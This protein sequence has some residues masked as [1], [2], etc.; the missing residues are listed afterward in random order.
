MGCAGF[1]K[2][3]AAPRD[4][5]RD[6]ATAPRVETRAAGS[7]LRGLTREAETP[8]S[9]R[10]RHGIFGDESPS[11]RTDKSIKNDQRHIVDKRKFCSD[12]RKTIESSGDFLARI[13]AEDAL[14]PTTACT[15]RHNLLLSSGLSLKLPARDY[16][17]GDLL[18]TTSRWLIYGETG[19]GKTLFAL[20]LAGAV[21]SGKPFLAWEG[22]R[23]ARVMYLDGEMPAE[24]FKERM[25]LVAEGATVLGHSRSS[26]EPLPHPLSRI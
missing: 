15:P 21:A 22:I 6:M 18:C 1:H 26:R 25:Q 24:T 8:G 23:R 9:Q 7:P 2:T 10:K 14:R 4:M 11:Y 3:A 19:V 5:K 12:S 13:A 16:L 20:E 17:F